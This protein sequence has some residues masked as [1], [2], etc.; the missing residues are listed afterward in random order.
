MV[1]KWQW[2]SIIISGALYRPTK[3][4]SGTLIKIFDWTVKH[5]CLQW[6]YHSISLMRRWNGELFSEKVG[7]CFQHLPGGWLIDTTCQPAVQLVARI[8]PGT[9]G[10]WRCDMIG[11]KWFLCCISFS[12][13]EEIILTG[14]WCT[15]T[16]T[17]LIIQR[18]K[19][20]GLF[21]IGFVLIILTIS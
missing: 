11:C 15:I 12:A 8:M 3:V 4:V 6:L 18:I 17:I 20:Y 5:T 2:L 13:P 16:S 19:I 1:L 9:V 10:T 14:F 7:L 21:R